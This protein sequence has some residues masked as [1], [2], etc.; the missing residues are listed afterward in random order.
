MNKS[1]LTLLTILLISFS[2]YGQE[3]H[4]FTRYFQAKVTV[5]T[6]FQRQYIKADGQ[7]STQDYNNEKLELTSTVTGTD[8]IKEI[9]EFL[10]YIR[11]LGHES[12]YKETF[13]KLNGKFTIY[14]DNGNPSKEG[15][16]KGNTILYTQAWTEDGEEKL[17]NGTG[18]NKYS[19]NE[20]NE[21]GYIEYIDSLIVSYYF[22][23]QLQKDTI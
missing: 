17:V 5:K 1:I 18:T 22:F 3:I 13:M 10:T 2:S 9:D 8:D 11:A 4:Y 12:K 16:Y 6:P 14:H 7:I 20:R 15:V 21:V 19:S 23:R